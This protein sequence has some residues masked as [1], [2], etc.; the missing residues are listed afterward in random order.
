LSV[1]EI[2]SVTYRAAKI[3]GVR[4]STANHNTKKIELVRG[5]ETDD[6]TMSACMEFG[7]RIGVQ[8]GVVQE[9]VG[10]SMQR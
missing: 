8:V 9:N 5:Q 4:F 6:E 10:A 7:Q 3:L 2:A 1:T